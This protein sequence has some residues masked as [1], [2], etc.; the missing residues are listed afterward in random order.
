MKKTVI[1]SMFSLIVIAVA[2]YLDCTSPPKN[3]ERSLTYDEGYEDGLSIGKEIGYDVGYNDGNDNGYQTGYSDGESDGY[4][5]GAVYTCLYYGDIDRAFQSATNGMAWFT[6]VDAY[7]QYISNIFDDK[8][9]RSTLVW[10]L[11]SASTGKN[12]TA[13]E[14]ELLISTF[15]EGLFA[16]NN[17]N[18][19]P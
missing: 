10:S 4:Y 13:A 15:G 12:V 14:K 1:I 5:S 17:I 7:D 8:E 19:S 2:I 6:F 3:D 11:V 9:T 16:R 18:L